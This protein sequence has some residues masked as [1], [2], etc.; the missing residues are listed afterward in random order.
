MTCAWYKHNYSNIRRIILMWTCCNFTMFKYL[1][2]DM[3]MTSN[4][5]KHVH[6]DMTCL[7]VLSSLGA[8]PLRFTV[9]LAAAVQVHKQRIHWDTSSMTNCI[10]FMDNCQ[11]SLL[12]IESQRQVK[13]K[14]KSLHNRLYIVH[15]EAAIDKLKQF[16]CGNEPRAY[17]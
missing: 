8:D 10:T 14:D 11:T 15:A 5:F 17:S 12:Q 9:N 3:Y 7:V 4:I 1:S 2:H 13:I 16:K 6:L